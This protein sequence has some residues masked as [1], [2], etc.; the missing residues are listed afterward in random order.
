[1][2]GRPVGC[3]CPGRRRGGSALTTGSARVDRR[4][5]ALCGHGCGAVREYIQALRDGRPL[6]QFEGLDAGE[7]R[8]LQQELESI[9]AVY[10]R[11]PGGA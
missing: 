10:G 4:V 6:P 7:R 2:V 11:P 1:M 3:P 8:L 5:E 9:M